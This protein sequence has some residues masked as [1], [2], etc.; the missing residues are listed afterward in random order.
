[1]ETTPIGQFCVALLDGQADY[2]LNL[3]AVQAD[4]TAR[5]IYDQIEQSQADA[6]ENG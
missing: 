2:L 1:M 3:L 5:V 6:I 4:E